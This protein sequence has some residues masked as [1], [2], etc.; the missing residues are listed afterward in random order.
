MY[1]P[2]R[3]LRTREHKYILNLAHTLEFPFASDLYHSATWQGILKRGDKTLG[4]RSLASFI[5]RPREELYDLKNDPEEL[6][7][8]A[9][10][11][12]YQ[13]VLNALRQR[14]KE[15]QTRTKD[16]W[17]VKDQHE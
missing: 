14:L 15:W 16:P 9:S 11:P 3:M 17:I 1:Y 6:K 7:N 13:D 8:V 10:D 12:R 5:N 2:A 4:K